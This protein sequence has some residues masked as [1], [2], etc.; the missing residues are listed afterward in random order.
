MQIRPRLEEGWST[1]ILLWAM[2]FVSAY[3]IQ[4]ADLIDGLQIIPVVGTIAILAGT[5]LAKSRFSANTVHIF[6]LV[7]GVFVVFYLVGTTA[8]FEDMTWRE[9]LIHP[10]DGM[11]ARQ[12]TWFAKLVD[13]GTSRDGLIFVF[14]TAV[15]F[16]LLG[17]TA[18]WYTFRYARVWRAI[19]PMGLVLLSVVY[20]YGGPRPLHYYPAIYAL[21]AALF[22]ARTYL[23]EQ[24]KTWRS[25][26]VRYEKGIWFTF[27]RAGLVAALLA[28]ILASGLPPLSANAAVSNALSDTRGPW[29]EFQDNWTRMFSALRT[30]GTNTADPY[31][32]TLVL[33]GPRTVGNIPVMDVIVENELPYVYW[34]AIVHDTYEDGGWHKAVDATTEHLP[35]EGPIDVP[36]TRAREVITQTIVTYFPNSSFIYGAPEIINADRIL[37]VNA[38]AD[39]NGDKL[40]SSV[41]SKY[42]LQQ[43]DAYQVTSRLSVADA[44]SLRAASTSYPRWVQETYLRVPDTVTPETLALAE[45]IAASYNNPFDKAMAIQSYLRENI[46]YNDQIAAPPEGMDP[47]HHTLFISQEGY[48]TYYASAMAIM[49]RSQGVPARLVSGYAQGSYDEE[50]HVY[51]VRASNAHTWVEVF[52]PSYGWIQFEPT[53]SLPVITR[54]ERLDESGTSTGLEAFFF[55]DARNSASIP[56]EDLLDPDALNN[57]DLLEGDRR[58]G[59]ANAGGASAFPVWRALGAVL[60]VSL[61]VGLSFLANEMNQRVE[62]DVDRSYNRLSSWAR[63]LGVEHRPDHTP[64]ERADSLTTIVPEGREPIRTLTRQY[65]LKQFSRARSY[66]EGFDPL[67]HWRALRPLLLRKSLVT[68]LQRLQEKSKSRRRRLR[69]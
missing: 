39:E 55:N 7:Y 9:R 41:R 63:W 2:M 40:V 32:D 13:G 1:L 12:I 35:E 67:P 26:A 24:E 30:Y 29:R 37:M 10:Q 16:W 34:A 20:Y 68:R 56:E 5:L 57:T 38:R 49:L 64:Y 62:K 47:I 54:P 50:S 60:T 31:Q 45:E 17:Y 46:A 42:V 14:Q 69:F 36:Y 28:L 53:A 11:I 4:Q 6:A 21:L 52:F 27:A 65:V 43:G 58:T 23:V 15:I 66:E 18:G 19:V 3:A 33:G 61:A 59:D 48:C 44:T 25:G 8:G 51:R 22:I